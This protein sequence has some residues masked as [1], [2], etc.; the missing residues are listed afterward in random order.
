M[1]TWNPWH[2]CTKISAG[3]RNCYMYRRDAEFGKD[4]SIVT[5]TASFSLPLKKDRHGQYKI[6][7][8]DGT[9]YTCF[10]SDFFHPDAD[11]WRAQA[12][13]IIRQRPDLTFFIV[14]KRPERFFISLPSDWRQGW[15]NVHICVTCENQYQA[16]T[17]LPLFLNLPIL[18]KSVI[19][20]PLLQRITLS[21]IFEKYPGMIEQVIC[22]GESG[23]NARMCDYSWVVDL[24]M[25][26]VC[27]DVPFHFMQ[28]GSLF[29]KGSRLYH[30]D[31][32]PEQ[33]RQA[34]K[35]AINYCP[36]H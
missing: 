3:C 11:E 30:I 1:T 12:W 32:H 26:C 23:P 5:R 10:T 25:D 4:S 9:V 35:A 21:R 22:G 18:H 16:E 6:K 7:P 20:E 14:T 28:T 8:E 27:H 2:G 13:E 33:I 17:R 19:A 15:D 34:E 29:K 36:A 31:S 24:M